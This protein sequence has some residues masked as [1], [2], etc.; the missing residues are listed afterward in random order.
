LSDESFITMCSPTLAGIKV[1]SLFSCE[2]PSDIGLKDDIRSFNRRLLPCGVTVIPVKQM[3]GKTLIYVY[4]PKLLRAYLA[5]D[6]VRRVLT[7]FGYDA[8]DMNSCIIRMI[9]RLKGNEF[10]HEIGLFLGYP[11]EDVIGFIENNGRNYKICGMWKVYGDEC[12]CSKIFDKYKMCTCALIEQ[13]RSG[14]TV[15]RLTVVV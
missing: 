9:S 11:P 15:E 14:S 8:T 4:R 3:N 5:Q 12:K 7:K 2:N 13:Y 6:K 1:A 10:P